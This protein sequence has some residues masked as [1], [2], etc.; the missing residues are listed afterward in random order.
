MGAHEKRGALFIVSKEKSRPFTGQLCRSMGKRSRIYA[1][2]PAFFS[3]FL[4]N[5][6][7]TS[8]NS[9]QYAQFGSEQK[10]EPKRTSWFS[11]F[12][13][14]GIPTPQDA[15]ANSQVR[16]LYSG[17]SSIVEMVAS[18]HQSSETW[19]HASIPLQRTRITST[20][21]WEPRYG[22]SFESSS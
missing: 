21:F 6:S 10:G 12:D 5:S 3:F 16:E 2:S 1:A 17:M 20:L 7:W 19:L 18:T 15:N 8:R 4:L 11:G 9:L 13:F 22:R 14:S